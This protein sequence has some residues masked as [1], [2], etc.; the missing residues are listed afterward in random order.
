V[1]DL[2]NLADC[3]SMNRRRWRGLIQ[4]TAVVNYE[5]VEKAC[6]EINRIERPTCRR[7]T[8]KF[9]RDKKVGVC[10]FIIY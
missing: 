7:G 2:P 3:L 5:A 4:K 8:G 1:D 6:G 10:L 9:N